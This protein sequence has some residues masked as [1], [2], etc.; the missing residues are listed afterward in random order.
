MDKRIPIS[1]EQKNNLMDEIVKHAARF[2]RF[3]SIECV[4]LMT[5]FDNGTTVFRLYTIFSSDIDYKI[6]TRCKEIAS[7][8]DKMYDTEDTRKKFGGVFQIAVETNDRYCRFAMHADE[9]GKVRN[10]YKSKI[11]YD[12][13]GEYYKIAHQFDSYGTSTT[14]VNC[15]DSEEIFS[16]NMLTLQK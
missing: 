5:F 16:E 11:L 8:Y 4:Y 1:E 7:K 2:E 14:H 10:L 12:K 3:P 9:V 6:F 13:D 15:Y